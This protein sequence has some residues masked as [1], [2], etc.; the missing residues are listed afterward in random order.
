MLAAP[1]L[2]IRL[3]T[4]YWAGV[5]GKGK[6]INPRWQPNKK[7]NGNHHH[8]P[9]PI[10]VI[11]QLPVPLCFSLVTTFKLFKISIKILYCDKFMLN[12]QLF[13]SLKI[14][15]CMVSWMKCW[16]RKSPAYVKNL[17]VPA[18]RK[19]ANYLYGGLTCC[20]TGLASRALLL[21]SK[22]WPSLSFHRRATMS[23]TPNSSRLR[24]RA[25]LET[26]S[27]RWCSRCSP[28]ADASTII[29]SP[30]TALCWR[31][32]STP[33][34][35]SARRS[36][37]STGSPIRRGLA[38]SRSGGTWR[39]PP[40]RTATSLSPPT[41]SWS[42]QRRRVTRCLR[43]RS[44]RCSAPSR[45]WAWRVVPPAMLWSPALMGEC[46][47]SIRLCPGQLRPW[48]QSRLLRGKWFV[49]VICHNL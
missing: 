37:P 12:K 1:T 4:N 23:S 17:P 34:A 46:G 14:R 25:W 43:R 38:T 5:S 49:F 22:Q 29:A 28:M 10:S 15:R 47:L 42:L 7:R 39:L 36:S 3:M 26:P 48:H 44:S 11:C 31:L 41:T 2:I 20:L 13:S 30:W 35:S 21:S 32:R 33:R 27:W 40:G 45:R 6:W 24:E 9:G 16:A 18:G 19:S 8:G